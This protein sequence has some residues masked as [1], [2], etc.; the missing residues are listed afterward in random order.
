LH[1]SAFTGAL[2]ELGGSAA[3]MLVTLT[4]VYS[5][6]LG[7]IFILVFGVGVIFGMIC[8]SCIVG[9]IIAYT[10]TNLEKMHKIIIAI[11]RSASIVFS[12]LIIGYS[13][14]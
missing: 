2:Q 3:I 8:I 4:T 9:S 1:K 14:I 7:L 6:E 12:I 10:A 11:T 13:I 5:V